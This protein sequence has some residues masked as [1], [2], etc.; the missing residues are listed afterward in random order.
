MFIGTVPKE[1]RGIIGAILKG[2]D[3]SK[4]ISVCCSGNYINAQ[5]VDKIIDK[6][7]ER[8]TKMME[9]CEEHLKNEKKHDKAGAMEESN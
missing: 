5:K 3:K 2:I 1:A 8:F 6:L 9:I 7:N 4:E